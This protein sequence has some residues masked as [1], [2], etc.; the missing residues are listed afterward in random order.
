MARSDEVVGDLISRLP[1]IDKNKLRNIGGRIE[2]L[3]A[4]GVTEDLLETHS[5]KEPVGSDSGL[6]GTGFAE[7]LQE[8]A[9]TC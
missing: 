7:H 5:Q 8:Q 9:K 3:P 6:E 1:D 4:S 2:D